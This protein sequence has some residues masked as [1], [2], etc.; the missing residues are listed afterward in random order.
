MDVEGKGLTAEDQLFVLMQAGLYLTAT[1]GFAAPEALAC[2]EC[3]ES[4][5]VS[6][7]QPLVLFS[8]LRGLW[9]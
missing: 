9:R 2:Y 8:A 3:A 6:L 4:L 5:C 1:R 7:N